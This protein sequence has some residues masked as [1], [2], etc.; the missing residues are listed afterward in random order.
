MQRKE[1]LLIHTSGNATRLEPYREEHLSWVFLGKNYNQL[2][3]W[4]KVFSQ[5]EYID[6]G[7]K[8]HA[9]AMQIRRPYLDFIGGLSKKYNSMPWWVSRISEKNIMVSPL[10]LYVCYLNI[11]REILEAGE[12]DWLCIISESYAVLQA[13]AKMATRKN[14]RVTWINK[15]RRCFMYYLLL[16]GWRIL[17]FTVKSL[18]KKIA[19]L[20]TKKLEMAKVQRGGNYIFLRTWINEKCFGENDEFVDLYFNR[21]PDILEENGFEV[22]T[23]PIIYNIKRTLKEAF[24]WFRK[25]KKRFLIPED[26]YHVNDYI[27]AIY[28]GFQQLFMPKGNLIFNGLDVT[29]LF[30]QEKMNTAFEIAALEF[31]MYYSLLRRLRSKE[32][33][34]KSF[35]Y[36]FENMFPEKPLSMGLKRF[37]PDAKAIGFQHSVLYPL[38]LCQYISNNEKAFIPLPDKIICSGQFFKDVLVKEGYDE[39]RLEVGAALRFGY[40]TKL[41]TNKKPKSVFSNRILIALPLEGAEELM[42]KAVRAFSSEKN[43]ALL[44]KSHPMLTSAQIARI[45]EV[46]GAEN[47]GFRISEGKMSKILANTDIMISMASG[48]IYDAMASGV[49]VVR[50]RKDTNLNFDPAD[51]FEENPFNFVAQSPEEI[52]TQVQK[53]LSLNDKERESLIEFGKDIVKR[54]FSPVMEETIKAFME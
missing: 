38:Q 39:E 3:K 42:L 6:I 20:G 5:A 51:W 52:K 32:I 4:R 2:L 22:V 43:Y 9:T 33:R 11:A 1:I 19:A 31:S 48:A 53:A 41:T 14:L 24:A 54:S 16:F 7:E 37:F 8:L 44:I 28:I 21:L 30:G 40:L 49:P 15:G 25:N 45:L 18:R 27:K 36:T 50:V 12:E 34:I 29:E 13:I 47:D 35:I 10:F 17:E 26:H 23:V 46:S